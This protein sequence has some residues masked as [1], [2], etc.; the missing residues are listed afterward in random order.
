VLKYVELILSAG[1]QRRHTRSALE[2]EEEEEEKY[3]PGLK[4]EGALSDQEM[5]FIMCTFNIL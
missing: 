4:G 3:T 5:R 1:G 2:E